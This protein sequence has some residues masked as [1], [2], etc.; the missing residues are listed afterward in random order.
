MTNPI[1]KLY[2]KIRKMHITPPWL[3]MAID[4]FW[5]A[6]SVFLTLFLRDNFQFPTRLN[7]SDWVYTPVLLLL[8]RFFFFEVFV[9]LTVPL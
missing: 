6:V 1:K 3:V 4:L 5:V 8:V 2:L 9:C 7:L